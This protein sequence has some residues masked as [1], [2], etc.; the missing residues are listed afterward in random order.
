MSQITTG[1]RS[2]LS[3]PQVYEL[4]SRMVGGERGRS[5]LVREY[6][7]PISGAR[8]LDL[9]CGPGELLEFLPESVSYVGVDLSE[10]YIGRARERFGKRAE[11]YV[12]DATSIN[13]DL[14]DF[15]L[16][17]AF[18]VLHHLDDDQAQGLFRGA[19]RVLR[20]NGR[21]ITVDPVFAAGQGRA[22]HLVISR[23]RGQHVRDRAAYTALASA[24]F[25]K[26][27][28]AVRDNLLRIPYTHCIIECEACTEDERS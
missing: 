21:A 15:D 7:R 28:S 20:Q 12:G 19:S 8:I 26:V 14:G 6:V 25:P 11:F 10:D 3:R 13:R 18:G 22:A 24:S 5:T 9:G 23:D 1:V 17:L 16:V 4:W 27:T 2:V